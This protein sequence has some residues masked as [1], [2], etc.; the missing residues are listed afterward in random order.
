MQLPAVSLHAEL[1]DGEFKPSTET[2]M[3][4]A[5]YRARKNLNGIVHTHSMFATVFSI[6]EKEIPPMMPPST[7]YAPV[8]V[9]PFELPGS[10]ELGQA[11]VNALGEN[12]MV[13]TLQNHGL[14]AAC[15]TLDRAFSAAEYIEECAQLA[16]WTM[17]AGKMNPLPDEAVQTLRDLSYMMM[18][19]VITSKRNMFRALIIGLIMVALVFFMA[20]SLTPLIT[21]AV[22]KALEG[23][24]RKDVC[25]ITKCGIVWTR[26]GSLFNK[27]GDVQLYKNLSAESIRME[28]EDSLKRLRT[29]Y[30]DIYMTHWQSVE[31]CFTPIAETM[32][33][34]ND[35]K[36]KGKIKAIGAANVTREHIEE[37]VKYG[38]LDIVQ[39]KYSIL[40][41]QVEKDLLPAC[42]ENGITFQ[43][44]SPLEQGLLSGKYSRDYQPKG[45]QA[46][47]KWFQP[48]YMTKAIDMMEKWKPLCE[49]YECS[50]A[51]LALAWIMKQGDDITV[52]NGC[53]KVYQ[54]D[55]NRKAVDIELSDDDAVWMKQLAD[56]II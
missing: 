11:A 32:D 21:P 53:S 43:A 20:T 31:P 22:G 56:K 24:E 7:P 48:E 42:R 41:R 49:K 36:V 3:H 34:L 40:D 14:L 30:L 52:L 4:T 47:K 37:Y 26:E 9:A 27:V 38:S 29:D 39:G 45:A 13:C 55:E 50:V 16:Y 28:I 2:P 12:K 1:L 35:L 18:A 23:L 17:Q 51:N 25:L 54:V 46:N 5:V 44:Y 8:P 19:P 33:V 6:L 10:E 15:P